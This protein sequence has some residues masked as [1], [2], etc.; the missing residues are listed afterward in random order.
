MHKCKPEHCI[1]ITPSHVTGDLSQGSSNWTQAW[2]VDS[3][4]Y[5]GFLRG[6]WNVYVKSTRTLTCF[7]SKPWWTPT[8]TLN[9]KC[10][11]I[12]RLLLPDPRGVVRHLAIEHSTGLI[13]TVQTAEG[14]SRLS[15][16]SQLGPISL[17]EAR[18]D[19]LQWP[20]IRE[21]YRRLVLEERIV[22]MGGLA[23]W[24]SGRPC[25]PAD[26]VDAWWGVYPRGLLEHAISE[27]LGGVIR[28]ISEIQDTTAAV[29]A[30]SAESSRRITNDNRIR[31]GGDCTYVDART[32]RTG[33]IE[34]QRTLDGLINDALGPQ[35]LEALFAGLSTNAR[36]R[37]LRG[38]EQ[39]C[40]FCSTRG[41]SP[42]IDTKEE[43][44]GEEILDFIMYEGRV[45]KLAPSTTRGKLSAVRYARIIGGRSDFS[46]YG[47][48]YKMMLTG[49]ERTKLATGLLPYNTDLLHWAW[50]NYIVGDSQ[51]SARE[52]RCALNLGFFFMMRG[53][54]LGN[55]KMKDI[56]FT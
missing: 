53:D 1:L 19:R 39:W 23:E 35:K 51:T 47:L 32:F 48:R 13:T 27:M 44:W 50:A 22:M 5:D 26:A 45:L 46:P 34:P 28:P 42:W 4:F 16:V 18:K 21:E 3:N 33:G 14:V 15:V 8:V 7:D 2:W 36:T 43:N 49:M 37:Y 6:A 54:E 38:W 17:H 29:V 11:Q 25:A 30:D 12:G 52:L 55:L 9:D 40:H 20:T 56:R 31:C 24:C 41:L 10:K